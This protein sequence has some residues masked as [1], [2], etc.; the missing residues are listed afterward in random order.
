MFERTGHGLFGDL[1]DDEFIERR[2][3]AITLMFERFPLSPVR[4]WA[5]P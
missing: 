4:A 2:M 5:A 1:P 3:Q